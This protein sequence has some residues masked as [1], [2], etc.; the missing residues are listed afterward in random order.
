ML[1]DL[2]SLDILNGKKRSGYKDHMTKHVI[3]EESIIDERQLHTTS[4]TAVTS[5]TDIIKSTTSKTKRAKLKQQGDELPTKKLKQKG[6]AE[7]TESERFSI[8]AI[9]G[10]TLQPASKGKQKAKSN[11]GVIS[12]SRLKVKRSSKHMDIS[13]LNNGISFGTGQTTQWF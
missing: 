6:R 7:D 3:A 1:N 10:D 8:A 13:R 4:I 5:D 11:S 12:V 9:S 2:P